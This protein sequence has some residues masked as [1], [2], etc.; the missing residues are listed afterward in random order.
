MP[1]SKQTVRTNLNLKLSAE[2]LER[3]RVRMLKVPQKDWIKTLIREAKREKII[4]SEQSAWTFRRRDLV[5][6]MQRRE[7]RRERATIIREQGID[8]SGRTIADE[9]AAEV[10][11]LILDCINE[12]DGKL[13]ITNERDRDI[14]EVLSKSISR[15]RDGD[16][17]MLKQLQAENDRLKK[18]QD[19]AQ[20]IMEA[21]TKK[22]AGGISPRTRDAMRAAL[23]MSKAG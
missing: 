21:E 7:L 20:K 17:Q 4:L 3:L 5:P 10:S 13:T 1:A 11:M 12:L 16:R 6:W 9:A 22:K 14:I 19:A 23:V 8:D 18:Q 15:V 2:K